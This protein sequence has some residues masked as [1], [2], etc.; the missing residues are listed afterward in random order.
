MT[1]QHR[2][3]NIAESDA[4]FTTNVS[5]CVCVCVCVFCGKILL[6]NFD[7]TA[8][9]TRNLSGLNQNQPKFENG[10]SGIEI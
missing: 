5:R 6:K 10:T 3:E 7:N 8:T 1:F 9:I 4:N 2:E